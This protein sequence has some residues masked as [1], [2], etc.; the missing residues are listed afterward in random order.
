MAEKYKVPARLIKSVIQQES[1]FNPTAGSHAGAQGLMQ[2]MPGTARGLGVTN[3]SD[4]RQSIEGG[5]KYLAQMLNA[6]GG[7]V[8]LALAAYNAGPGNVKKYGGIPPFTETQNYVRTV[9][10][11]YNGDSTVEGVNSEAALAGVSSSGSA[12]GAG[13]SDSR[14]YAASSGRNYEVPNFSLYDSMSLMELMALAGLIGPSG[15]SLEALMAMT[16][17]QL[18]TAVK[19]ALKSGKAQQAVSSGQL[20]A[21]TIQSIVPDSF[22][23]ASA[24]PVSLPMASM[25]QASP[26]SMPA[27]VGMPTVSVSSLSGSVSV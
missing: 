23:G 25:E 20:S 16:P 2:L 21:E 12:S 6:Q 27:I 8:K 11:S 7:D 9:M 26:P 17:E 15:V 5:T 3:T 14:D 24:A 19:E 13:S 18:K 4:P 1:G 22:Q 10:G